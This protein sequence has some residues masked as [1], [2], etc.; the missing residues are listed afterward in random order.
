MRN[1]ATKLSNM[2]DVLLHI[3]EELFLAKEAGHMPY[4]L[5]NHGDPE[6]DCH[7]HYITRA[8]AKLDKYL[9]EV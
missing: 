9:E 7:Q 8:M 1:V 3:R 4:C 2:L 5:V 6:C